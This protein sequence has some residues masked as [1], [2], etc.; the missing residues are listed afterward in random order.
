MRRHI[1][2]SVKAAGGHPSRLGDRNPH[3]R[4]FLAYALTGHV[5]T[6]ETEAAIA[7]GSG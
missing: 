4:E 3:R 5:A 2:S 7:P 1:R 6:D